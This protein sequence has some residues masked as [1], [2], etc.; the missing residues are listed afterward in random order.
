MTAYSFIKNVNG[1]S[2]KVFE[3]KYLLF[4]LRFRVNIRKKCFIVI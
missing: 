1:M 2:G 3:L 4:F